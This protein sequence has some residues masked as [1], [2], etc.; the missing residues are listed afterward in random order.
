MTGCQ[1]TR[2]KLAGRPVGLLLGLVGGYLGPVALERLG[3]RILPPPASRKAAPR[4]RHAETPGR[5]RPHPAGPNFGVGVK[6]PKHARPDP[7]FGEPTGPVPKLPEPG[8]PRSRR[9][10]CGRQPPGGD[11][12]GGW[13]GGC[14]VAAPWRR[15]RCLPIAPSAST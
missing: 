11:R 1:L 7:E 2:D 10:A 14:S 4:A 5:P 8:R 12:R 9:L 13:A 6:R 3:D 15:A